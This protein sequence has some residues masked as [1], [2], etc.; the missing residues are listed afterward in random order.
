[1]IALGRNVRNNVSAHAAVGTSN[2]LATSV[3][4]EI[5]FHKILPINCLLI[6]KKSQFL[7]DARDTRDAHDAHVLHDA[8]DALDA[9]DFAV[10]HPGSIINF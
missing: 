7:H 2:R 5:F 9:L 6:V 1:M 10:L 3:A 4:F 8:P